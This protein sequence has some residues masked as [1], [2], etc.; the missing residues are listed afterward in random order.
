MKS[1]SAD[2]DGG[3]DDEGIEEVYI[4]ALRFIIQSGSA[5]ISMIQR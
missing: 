4:E 5:S 2:G 3:G 1:Q